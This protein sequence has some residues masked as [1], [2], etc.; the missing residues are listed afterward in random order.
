MQLGLPSRDYFL[1]VSKEI[2]AYHKYMVDVAVLFGADPEFAIKDLN[3]VLVLE[4]ILANVSI[5]VYVMYCAHVQAFMVNWSLVRSYELY[6]CTNS[7]LVFG[8][9]PW[10]IRMR[11]F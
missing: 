7:Q 2:E 8:Q 6:A 3:D 9:V 4:T 5:L 11:S 1:N 10:A